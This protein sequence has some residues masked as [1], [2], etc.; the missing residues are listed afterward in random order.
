MYFEEIAGTFFI[1]SIFLLINDC[2][3]GVI[4][5][6]DMSEQEVSSFLGAKHFMMGKGKGILN[7]IPPREGYF[8]SPL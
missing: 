4:L 2:Q 1:S 3:L 6:V 5:D 8:S 7:S